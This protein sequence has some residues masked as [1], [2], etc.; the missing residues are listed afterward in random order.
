VSKT[1]DDRLNEK[2]S[3]LSPQQRALLALR[4]SKTKRPGPVQQSAQLPQVHPDP[5][6]RYQEF[7]LSDIQQAYLIGRSEGVELGNITCHNYFEVDVVDWNAE[8]FEAALH[9]VIERHDM[10]RCI[11]L[12]EGRQRI[13]Q[14][15]PPYRV[16]SLDFRGLEPA[17][18]AAQS[19]EIRGRMSH[20]M[21]RSDRWPLFDFVISHLD[22][23]RSRLHISLDMLIADGRSFEI[24]FGELAL[25]YCN[26]GATLPPL[27]LTFRDYLLAFNALEHTDA[28]RKS[29]EYWLKRLP[30]M[31][32]SPE[33]PLA[34]NPAA[35]Q[36]PRYIRRSARIDAATWKSLKAKGSRISLTPSGVLL[37]AYAEVLSIWSKNPRFTI[38]LTLFN[39]PPLH[40]QAN[41]IIGDFTSVSLQ[42]VDN[43]K[44]E[45]FESRAKRLKEQL[46]QDLDHRDFGGVRV[47]RELSALQGTGP[48][49]IMPVVFTSLLNLADRSEE[50]TWANRIGQTGFAISQT[51]QVYLDFIVN[52]DRSE[53]VISWDAVEELFPAGML[54]DMFEA[55]QHLLRNLATK[56]SSWQRTLVENALELIP[57]AQMKIRRRVNATE[58][59]VSDELLH[60]LFLKQ[61][62]SNP[63]QIAIRSPKRQ[64]TYEEVCRRAGRVEEELLRRNVGP[65]DVVAVLMEK[66]WEQAVAVLGIH[67]AGGAYLPIDSELPAERQ[68][69]LIADAKVKVVLIQSAVQDHASV[70]EGVDVLAVDQ[71]EPGE[72]SAPVPR[73]RQK[74]EDLA[75]IIYTSGST[76]NPKGVMIDHRGA[77][78]TIL[79]VNQRFGIGPQD[80]VLALSKLSF[81]LSVYD[82]FGLLAAGGTIVFP[83][84]SLALDA[85]H[86]AQ[87]VLSEKITVWNT[88]PA[89]MQLLVEQAQNG[90]SIG[91][92][93]RVVMMSGDWIPINL[94]GQ[95]RK[96]LPQAKII[97]LG[98]ATEASIWSILYPIEQIDPNWK[99]V[100][101]GKPMLN[102]TFHVLSAAKAPCP[103]WVPGQLHI[104]GIGLAKGYWQ[105]ERKTDASFGLNSVTGERLYRTGDL[106]RYLPDGNIEFLGREDFQVK[107][108]G[109]R[110][111]L[112]EIEARLQAHPGV[113]NCVVA[114]REDEPGERRLVGYVILNPGATLDSAALREY[115]R[116]KLPEYMVPLA[117]VS[118]N[119]FPLT[120][121][122]KV[123]RKALPA[124][125][126]AT[127]ATGSESDA[128]RDSLEMQL[129]QLWEK[130]LNVRPI[131]LR[132]NF[133]DLGGNSLG[134]VRLFS[135]MR[136]LFGRGFPLSVLFQA[137]TVEKLADIVR[138]GGWA[139]H[140]TSLVPI[141]PGGTKPPFYCVHGGG[142][143][144]LIYRELA[145]YLGADYP[146]YGLQARGL[147]GSSD[148]L[149]TIEAMAESYLRE[150]CELQPEG[151]YYLGGFCMGGQVAVEIARRLVRD[152]QQ[153]NLLFVIDA[154]NFN[155]IIPQFSLSEKVGN[156]GQK[157]K[158]HS[159]NVLQLSLKGQIDYL[160]EKSKLAVRREMER[161]RI[162][163][164][165][166][167]KLNPHGDVLRGTREEFLEDINDHAFL[168]YVPDVYPGKMTI[169]KPR[170]N[171]TFLH[172]PFNGWGEIA[173]GGLEII[174]LPSNPGG[175]FLEPYVQTLA[176]KLKEQID[177]AVSTSA[178]ILDPPEIV[179][180]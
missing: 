168:A 43:S 99:S 135:E 64:F 10:L 35:V 106:G 132:D 2:L 81:D 7:P 54:D 140:W 89:L 82:I 17:A 33:L 118:L 57:A 44:P 74:P 170:R 87:L 70:P 163:M 91:K 42:E 46:W 133:F 28:F 126:Q 18:A 158:F 124:P 171:Y 12:P 121:N 58:S 179:L 38:N 143:N 3:R 169:C 131:R 69:Y 101:Y 156:F 63:K 160:V 45:S 4:F 115:L 151:P 159:L 180:K 109:Y 13:L 117:F 73:R 93:L 130:V 157:I 65:N 114:V 152:G 86:W 25:L 138:K 162:K 30:T 104:G 37:A 31:P 172:D 78:N 26:P 79:D 85:S 59:P 21:H 142:G 77:V 134:A 62:A 55:F 71:L 149:T 100:P 120:I 113:E 16:K 112:G 116:S 27:D 110:I 8:R 5:R 94:P 147:D 146:F 75:Y 166:L 177:R 34:I 39:R 41:D 47:L 105:D 119:Q 136:K 150:I 66:G 165:H 145:R 178:E 123:N 56:E 88:V 96:L 174:E 50:S 6:N 176:E 84:A 11:V 139:P 51:P 127:A 83:T 154:H 102:Q 76:G 141:Q 95:I 137:P 103:A 155:G 14:Q 129:I 15:V 61:V 53:L 153:V 22:T 49:A 111:E 108:Q 32:P 148:Y 20:M 36:S 125:V 24:L 90:E 122:G 9:K 52:E 40:E 164:V 128:P 161:L 72:A 68:R 144:V 92:T 173:A 23:H 60:T 19:E 67:F 1:T 80:R 48:K 107:V 97:S 98:G 29:R 167:F 175:I